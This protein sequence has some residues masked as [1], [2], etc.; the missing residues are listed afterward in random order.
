MHTIMSANRYHIDFLGYFNASQRPRKRLFIDMRMKK[1]PLAKQL[2]IWPEHFKSIGI[3]L[4]ARIRMAQGNIKT[5][6]PCPLLHHFHINNI[7]LAA[8]GRSAR[9]A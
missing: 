7:R 3:M 2:S 5:I 4:P 9:Q 1:N 8:I 6:A